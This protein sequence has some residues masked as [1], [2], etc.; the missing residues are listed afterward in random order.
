MPVPVVL[1]DK[2]R[3]VRMAGVF[4]RG[5]RAAEEARGVYDI[6]L[7]KCASRAQSYGKLGAEIQL[8]NSRTLFGPAAVPLC[9]FATPPPG[10]SGGFVAVSARE[11]GVGSGNPPPPGAVSVPPPRY[12]PP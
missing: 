11:A 3:S 8:C 6:D 10:T 2:T 4:R 1:G 5:C 7:H 12:T 9:V